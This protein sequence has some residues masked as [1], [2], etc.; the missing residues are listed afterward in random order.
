MGEIKARKI[1]QNQEGNSVNTEPTSTYFSHSYTLH[2]KMGGETT[3]FNNM[4]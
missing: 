4:I 3:D 2:S 1:N